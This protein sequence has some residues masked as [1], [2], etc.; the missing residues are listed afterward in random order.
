M[1]YYGKL[2]IR[3]I[4]VFCVFFPKL[5]TDRRRSLY[6]N[7]TLVGF[8]NIQEMTM[9]VTDSIQKRKYYVLFILCKINFI[10][11]FIVQ[12]KNIKSFSSDRS[13]ISS[14]INSWCWG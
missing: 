3:K 6:F 2:K 5:D 10:R 13:L 4:P 9:V 11:V 7:Q 8:K 1:L 12:L 14:I